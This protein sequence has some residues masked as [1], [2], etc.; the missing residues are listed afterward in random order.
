MKL[1]AV[2]QF[3]GD[4]AHYSITQVKKGIYDAKLLRY[5]GS[6]GVTPPEAVTLVRGVRHWVGSYDEPYFVDELGNAI[7]ER[8]R[9]GNPH[10][11]GGKR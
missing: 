10:K 4:R 6:S 9:H 5:E 2:V 8:V 7:E 11:Q 1:K 3:L